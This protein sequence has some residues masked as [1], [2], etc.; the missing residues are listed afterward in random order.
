MAESFKILGRE[1]I[2]S[3]ERINYVNL[4]W[5]Y[6]N[7][8]YAAEAKML[9]LF[10]DSKIVSSG[11]AD[12]FSSITDNPFIKELAC[13]KYPNIAGYI[14][15]RTKYLKAILDILYYVTSNLND[16][17]KANKV[18]LSM[19]SL[20]E[21]VFEK[22][23]AKKV[24][25][26]IARYIKENSKPHVKQFTFIGV[27]NRTTYNGYCYAFYKNS[28]NYLDFEEKCLKAV[29]AKIEYD[30]D[31]SIQT[32]GEDK[33]ASGEVILGYF[34][35]TRA[36]D[37]ITDGKCLII[38]NKRIYTQKNGFID[39]SQ[40]KECYAV[41]KLLLAHLIVKLNDSS[42]IQLPVNKDVMN[43]AADMIN[44]LLKAL[45]NDSPTDDSTKTILNEEYLQVADD[46]TKTILNEE[47]LQVA[48]NTIKQGFSSLF[49]KIKKG[50]ENNWTCNCGSFNNGAF[51]PKCGTKRP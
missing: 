51:C 10:P 6:Q 45:K 21:I 34:Q 18:Y 4:K 49:G 36:L 3:Q 35:Y 17:L 7:L 25:G 46:S 30:D 32:Y 27:S 40:F 16:A 13:K 5:E 12:V 33:F 42:E 15:E 44:R 31:I 41:K 48:A 29:S 50:N 23:S 1:I 14:D 22:S 38:T 37:L 24:I 8:S 9:E 39:I 19:D 11:N 43:E 47:Y 2:F 20:L 28:D 26:N